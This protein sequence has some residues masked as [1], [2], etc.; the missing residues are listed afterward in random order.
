MGHVY[1]IK[2]INR[3]IDV[4]KV[5]NN[6]KSLYNDIKQYQSTWKAMNAV[7]RR[8]AKEGVIE[9]EEK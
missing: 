8:L 3:S 5:V 7:V 1:Q 6:M 4:D 2:N 9:Y